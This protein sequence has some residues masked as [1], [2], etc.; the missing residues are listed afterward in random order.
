[1]S[2][3]SMVRDFVKSVNHFS[4]ERQH[5]HCHS[6]RLHTEL[7]R[8]VTPSYCDCHMQPIRKL[9]GEV[10]GGIEVAK[11][12]SDSSALLE[13]LANSHADV[14]AVLSVVEGPW[15]LAFWQQDAQT[16]WIARDPI[17]AP[18]SKTLLQKWTIYLIPICSRG[19]LPLVR[20]PKGA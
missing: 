5:T 4:Q 7:D 14:P 19:H 17:G 13:A 10:F 16:L 12:C 2:S 9:A 6:A 1:M 18:P 20:L 15:A 3:F 11:G 8:A